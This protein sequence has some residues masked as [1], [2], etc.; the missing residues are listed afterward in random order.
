VGAISL[1]YFLELWGTTRQCWAYYT[2]T[3]T[4]LFTVLAHGM[5]AVA[6][7]RVIE[8][9]QCFMRLTIKKLKSKK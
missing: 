2:E 3:T 4:P 5:A 9:I 8:I 7:W 6:I 1:G